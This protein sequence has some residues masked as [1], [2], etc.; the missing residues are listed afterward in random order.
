MPAAEYVGRVSCV[1]CHAEQ[2]KLWQGSHHD[3]AMQ[4]AN[5][6]TVPGDFSVAAFTFVYAVALNSTGNS[7][8]AIDVLQDT[9]IRFPQD[10]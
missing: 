2:V 8:L 3:L 4:H 6:N 5:E 1:Q 10:S 7:S 9:Q